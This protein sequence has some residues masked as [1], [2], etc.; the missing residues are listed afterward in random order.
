V[1]AGYAVFNFSHRGMLMGSKGFDRYSPAPLIARDVEDQERYVYRSIVIDCLLAIK[2]L[3]RLE[4]VDPVRLGVVG[5]SQGGALA[6]ITAALAH[7]NLG[8]AYR[9]QGRTDDSLRSF[10]KAVESDPGYAYAY[11]LLGLSFEQKGMLD[12]AISMNLKALELEPKNVLA[13][14]NL[15]AAYMRKGLL[16]QAIDEQRQ[17]I[18]LA[19]RNPMARANLGAAYGQ[20][21]LLDEAIGELKQALLL[22]PRY[23]KA[24]YN[25]AVA[26]LLKND[27]KLADYHFGRAAQLGHPATP[28]TSQRTQP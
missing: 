12:E 25:L 19:P 1:S 16:D 18:S 2:V 4:K 21:G 5:T 10:Q 24:H 3:S 13:R 15:G 22:D 28:E 27:R 8:M 6:L 17:A 14:I 11:I 23:A 26:Y 9:R 7:T 20:K